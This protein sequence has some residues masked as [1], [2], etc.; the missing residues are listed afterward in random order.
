MTGMSRDGR[1]G[2]APLEAGVTASCAVSGQ[3]VT[4]SE[5][6]NLPSDATG[7]GITKV[8]PPKYKNNGTLK[9]CDCSGFLEV[10]EGDAES[11]SEAE[12]ESAELAT[13]IL[14]L[15]DDLQRLRPPRPGHFE[16]ITEEGTSLGRLPHIEAV[17]RRI[18]C[19]EPGA[20]LLDGHFVLTEAAHAEELAMSRQLRRQ[21]RE[22]A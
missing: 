20:V 6:A 17:L 13:A 10:A 19:G 2:D 3:S 21:K 12:S 18:K 16:C 4:E 1:G 15:A 5:Q 14:E 11:L 8:P 9:P 7:R 22:D